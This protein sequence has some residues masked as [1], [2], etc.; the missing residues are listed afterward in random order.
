M[1]QGYHVGSCPDTK[2]LAG[3]HIGEFKC[4]ICTGLLRGASSRALMGWFWI[5]PLLGQAL[6]SCPVLLHKKHFRSFFSTLGCR[7]S[8]AEC[9][10]PLQFTHVISARLRGGISLGASRSGPLICLL[11]PGLFTNPPPALRPAG[12]KPRAFMNAKT[13]TRWST[14]RLSSSGY[15][16]SSSSS[17]SPSMT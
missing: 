9:P 13:S 8:D 6:A 10:L 7:Q 15:M 14:S 12:V 4:S 5:W 2:V 16:K 11:P 17:Y 1:E 3:N